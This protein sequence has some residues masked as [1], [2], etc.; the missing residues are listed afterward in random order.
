[1]GCQAV[2]SE[3]RFR[4]NFARSRPREEQPRDDL[5][6]ALA[7]RRVASRPQHI[8]NPGHQKEFVAAALR[9]IGEDKPSRSEA[10]KKG[11]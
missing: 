9:E 2:K 5:T 3:L 7:T 6:S 4:Q 8:A 11:K 1:M 10:D